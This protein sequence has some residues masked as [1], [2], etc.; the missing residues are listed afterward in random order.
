MM[1]GSAAKRRFQK[2]LERMAVA[3]AEGLSSEARKSRPSA[4]ATP[5]TRKRFHE[6]H[7]ASTASG[8]WPP[9][10]ETL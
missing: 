5:R 7:A 1:A 6:I 10:A 2:A 8:N 3:G 9:L 4:G